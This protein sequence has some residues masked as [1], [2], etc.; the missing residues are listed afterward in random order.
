[1][2][3]RMTPLSALLGLATLA[4]AAPETFG[5]SP[6]YDRRTHQPA[7]FGNGA[8]TPAS[9]ASFAGKMTH[10]PVDVLGAGFR[11]TDELIDGGDAGHAKT[12][13]AAAL[14]LDTDVASD[15]A[16]SN[17]KQSS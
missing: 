11:K 1:M 7:D 9:M 5:P 2:K 6:T 17:I 13:T 10:G 8:A 15:A 14:G 12:D 3:T 16:G 4:A